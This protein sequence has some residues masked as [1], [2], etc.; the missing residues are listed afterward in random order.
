MFVITGASGNTGKVAAQKLLAKGEKVRVIGRDRKRLDPFVQRGAEA[1]VCELQDGAALAKAF[2]GARGVYA[3]IPV[4]P[5]DPDPRGSQEKISDAYAFALGESGVAYA[6]ILSSVGADKSAKTGPILGLRNFEEK[7][8]RLPNLNLLRL[9]A[10]YFLENLLEQ[11][12]P[13]QALGMMAGDLRADLD[14]PMIAARDIGAYVAD[15]LM[16]QNFTGKVTQELLGAEDVSYA[17]AAAVIGKAIGKPL[18]YVQLPPEQLKPV[19]LQAG[20]S[21]AMADL[22]LEMAESINNGYIVPLERRS[23]RNTTHT[24]LD[25]FVEEVFVPAFKGK[26]VSA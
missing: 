20:M 21:G 23:P 2:S 11:I 9:R 25:A 13:I 1:I 14:F 10:T 3:M 17:R 26:A 18:N 8:N 24:T 12:N 16:Q 15:A 5:R 22:I 6:V 19:L 4:D 7:L